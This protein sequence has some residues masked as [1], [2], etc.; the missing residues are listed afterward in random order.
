MCILYIGIV[1]KEHLAK[2]NYLAILFSSSLL[3]YKRP[4]FKESPPCVND[5]LYKQF[6]TLF[7][8]FCSPGNASICCIALNKY[9]VSS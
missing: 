2:L 3:E 7:H 6:T 9:C 1:R 4:S 8:F 5:L